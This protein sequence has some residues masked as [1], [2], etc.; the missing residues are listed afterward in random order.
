LSKKTLAIAK[1]TG[2]DVIVQVKGNQKILLQDCEKVCKTKN[3]DDI[4]TEPISKAR[5]RIEQRKA[6][7]YLS[8][9]FTNKDWDFAKVVVKIS[10]D[11]QVFDTKTKSW[12]RRNEISYY[13]STIELSAY[14]F[15]KA[16]REHW[17]VENSNHYVRD[18][19]MLEDSSR[20]RINAHIFAKLRS[21]ALNI[22][23]KNG[24]DNVSNELYKNS[25]KLEYVLNYDG[26]T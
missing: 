3:P 24:V 4:Y 19:T 13:I 21:F 10:R 14:T 17:L 23:R 9:T 6:E 22:L 26:I 20:I 16:I 8:P 1:K 15:N 11:I 18:V 5:G 25:L 7:I 2:N 12:E